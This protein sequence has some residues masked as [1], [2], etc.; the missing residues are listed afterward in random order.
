ML[1]H[2]IVV[3]EDSLIVL[4]F[5]IDVINYVTGVRNGSRELILV[6]HALERIHC[7][8]FSF[9]HFKQENE[10]LMKNL[11]RNNLKYFQTYIFP[12]AIR[13]V[14][15]FIRDLNYSHLLRYIAGYCLFLALC[16]SRGFVYSGRNLWIVNLCSVDL[17]SWNW[18]SV[19]EAINFTA[20][21]LGGLNLI[22]QVSLWA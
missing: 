19:G 17:R 5:T 6:I 18:K 7:W 4:C 11:V 10:I 15:Q 21:F 9:E 8:S 14:K 12:I 1:L 20:F 16:V 2:Y 13:I 22:S 3:P